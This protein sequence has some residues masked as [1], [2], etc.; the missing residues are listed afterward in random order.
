MSGLFFE[1]EA[2][3][4]PFLEDPN[5]KIG[6]A[7]RKKLVSRERIKRARGEWGQ[8]MKLELPHGVPGGDGWSRDVRHVIKNDV[9]AVLVRPIMGGV[10]LMIST[11]SG[12]RPSWPEMQRIKDETLGEGVT[13]VEIYPPKAEVVDATNAYHL[14]AGPGL[15]MPP[16]FS[17][18]HGAEPKESAA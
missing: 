7:E 17:I 6:H 14:W 15:R 4:N 12:D 2:G 8:W 3:V 11:L 9:F 10:H 18:H 1:N 13:A 5:N 16:S